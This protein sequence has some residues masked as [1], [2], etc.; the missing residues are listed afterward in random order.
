LKL[1]FRQNEHARLSVG[2][3]ISTLPIE[4]QAVLAAADVF[5]TTA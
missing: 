4:F 1:V 5:L 3:K 2:L